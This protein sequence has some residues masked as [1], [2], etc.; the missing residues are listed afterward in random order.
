M[1]R[2]PQ[3]RQQPTPTPTT[4]GRWQDHAACRGLDT[5]L[6]YP[7]QGESTAEAK[8]VCATC[9]VQTQ[10]AEHGLAF[11]RFGIWGATSERE[12]RA[13]RRQRRQPK[14]TQEPAA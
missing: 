13:I 3:I 1:P 4:E 10:C 8:A 7:G 11:E 2:G 12:R 5:M 6:F 9:P 14:T